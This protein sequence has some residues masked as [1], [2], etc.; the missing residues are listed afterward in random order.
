MIAMNKPSYSAIMT[1]SPTK[2]VIVFV[3]SRRQTRL[4]S[5]DFISL[6]ANGDNP[7][8]FL[9]MPEVQME[10]ILATIKDPALKLSLQFG[11]GLHHAGIIDSDRKTVEEL[12][13]N[14]KIQVL[15]ATS[16][17][18]WGVN[19]PA[20]LVVIKGTEFYDAKSKG[21]KDFPITDVLQMMGRAGRPQFDDS[22]VA[23]VLVHDIKK[24]FYKKFLHQPFPVESSM[25]LCLEEHLNAEISSGTIK[26]KQDAMDWVTWTYLYRRVFKNPSFYGCEDYDEKSVNEFLSRLIED[27]LGRLIDGACVLDD[28]EN[29]VIATPYGKI[30]SHYYL[31]FTTMK[32]LKTRLNF[33]YEE[34][35]F[36]KLLRILCDADEFAELPVR[37]NEDLLNMELGMQLPIPLMQKS[38]TSFD[39]PLAKYSFD[40]PHSKAFLLLQAHLSRFYSLPVSDYVTDTNTVLDQ[41]IRIIQAM[42]DVAV[43]KGY[44]HLVRGIILLMQCIKQAVWDTD[45]CLLTLPHLSLDALKDSQ[46]TEIQRLQSSLFPL[47]NQNLSRTDSQTWFQRR[48]KDLDKS[49][50][51]DITRVIEMIP[52]CDISIEVLDPTS[53]TDVK[54]KEGRWFVE[55][56]KKYSIK[57]TASLVSIYS[58]QQGNRVRNDSIHAPH[59]HKLQ[60]E[61]WFLIVGE[62]KRNSLH[63]F[64]RISPN[65]SKKK[66]EKIYLATTISHKFDGVGERDLNIYLDCD[67]YRGIDVMKILRA[68]I[69]PP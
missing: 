19:L 34:K 13:Y 40:S 25:H 24:N 68:T 21:Y 56:E 45:S 59:F 64:K 6:C 62:E 1:H 18:A 8:R 5:K 39:D 58:N 51:N 11:I 15:I 23:C 54:V 47:I 16:T 27:A 37:H 26:S 50:I 20:H 43:F 12:F 30:A 17:L 32:T 38:D 4:T 67:G 31:K 28:E 36:S 53:K 33:Q 46:D 14:S 57:I 42:I 55:S 9:H 7:R 52:F 3:S 41:T 29:H 60:T 48:F 2:P 10:Q 49:K 66:T 22:G 65:L 35:Y 61:G 44:L 63:A 69:N